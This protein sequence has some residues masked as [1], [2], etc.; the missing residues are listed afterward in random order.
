MNLLVITNYFNELK[1][2]LEG[3]NPE[4]TVSYDETNFTDDLGKIKVI[5]CRGS[6]HAE[7]IIDGSKSRTS[8][9][10]AG[11]AT[12]VLLPIYIVYK[13]DHLYDTWIQN[14]PKGTR[15]NRSH[16]GWFDTKIFEDWFFSIVL[17]YLKKNDNQKKVM[18]GDNL[19]KVLK[20]CVDNN[21]S[22]VLLPPN[23][24]HLSQ[25]LDVAYFRPLKIKWR[26]VLNN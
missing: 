18:I 20:F 2:T 3:V 12:G 25:P 16:S 17:P 23:S 1:K 11:T 14:A 24:T 10:F 6:K 4:A 26:E 7:R 9:M 19:A 8:L 13:S 5:V 21:I 15:F 22:F